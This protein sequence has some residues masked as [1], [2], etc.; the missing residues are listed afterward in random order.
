MSI[1]GINPGAKSIGIAVFRN[2]DLRDWR[3]KAIDGKWSDGKLKMIKDVISELIIKHQ[4]GVVA[5]KSLHP[6][7]RSPQLAQLTDWI[8]LFSIKKNIQVHEYSLKDLEEFYSPIER[9]NK[10]QLAELVGIEYPALFHELNRERSH[11]NKYFIRMFEAVALGAICFH[12]LDG[13]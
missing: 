3:I 12:E 13:G 7:L 9:I 11:R 2:A 4:P 10:R 6:S 5:L 8:K 1:L